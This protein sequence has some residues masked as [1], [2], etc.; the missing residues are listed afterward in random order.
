ME[1]EVGN[2]RRNH[3]VPVPAARDLEDLNAML[4]DGCREAVRVGQRLTLRP[5]SVDPRQQRGGLCALKRRSW[6][7]ALGLW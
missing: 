3:L 4:L 5:R 6:L 2:F 1:G 7:A